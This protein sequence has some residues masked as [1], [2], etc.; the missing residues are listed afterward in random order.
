MGEYVQDREV[1]A[2]QEQNLYQ[3][4]TGQQ[5][6]NLYRVITTTL[7]ITT[8]VVGI[9]LEIII[10]FLPDILSFF[11]KRKQGEQISNQLIGTVIPSI[12]NKLRS[13]L[14]DYFNEQVN[15]LINEQAELLDSQIQAKQNE[16]AE[17]EKAKKDAVQD[18]ERTIAELIDIRENIRSLANRVIFVQ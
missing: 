8:N 12:K 16:I 14:P 15:L 10:V 9:A 11:Q 5:G 3:K 1:R 7:A 13:E 18:I 2:G 4:V 6:R 17:A